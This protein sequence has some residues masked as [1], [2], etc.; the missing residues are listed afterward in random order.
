MLSLLK[1]FFKGTFI[2]VT[3]AIGSVLVPGCLMIMLF[4][5]MSAIKCS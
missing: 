2:W 3:W 1:T 5:F 4:S